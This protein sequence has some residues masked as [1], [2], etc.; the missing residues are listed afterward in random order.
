MFVALLAYWKGRRTYAGFGWWVASM[1]LASL[2]VLALVLRDAYPVPVLGNLT[3]QLLALIWALVLVIGTLLFFGR[4]A[5]DPLT[6][7]A[8]AF[9]IAAMFA[10]RLLLIPDLVGIAFGSVAIGLL[11]F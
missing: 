8:V 3:S 9:G 10:G 5:R 2:T 1:G 6:W 4:G 7:G 11:M